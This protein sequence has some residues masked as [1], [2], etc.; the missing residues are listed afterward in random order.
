MSRTAKLFEKG[1]IVSID[2]V[3]AMVIFSI[4][5]AS[6]L[7]TENSLSSS[8][9]DAEEFR[10]VQNK[11]V[12]ISDQ[13]VM[14]RGDPDGWPNASKIKSIGL[15][16]RD[17]R[18]SDSKITAL[19][20]MSHRSIQNNLST[21]ANSIYIQYLTITGGNCTV[22]STNISAG[23]MPSSPRERISIDRFVIAEDSRNCTLRVTLWRS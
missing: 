13:L 20:A 6:V 14:T 9:R 11:L 8:V 10:L 1:Q 12:E 2:V 23:A 3:F 15:A 22:S 4:A 7:Y 21:G 16:Y 19:N 17:H 5:L 18:I